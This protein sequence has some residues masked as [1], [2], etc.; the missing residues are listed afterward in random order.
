MSNNKQLILDFWTNIS[1][2]ELKGRL[3]FRWQPGVQQ[4]VC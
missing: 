3:H 4:R 2:K 1:W